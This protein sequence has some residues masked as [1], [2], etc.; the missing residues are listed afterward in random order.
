MHLPQINPSQ[1]AMPDQRRQSLAIALMS[2]R[3]PGAVQSPDQQVAALVAL[4]SP[5]AQSAQQRDPRT[6]LRG[7]SNS[8]C[9]PDGSKLAG[10]I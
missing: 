9:L 8:G 1:P 6:T 3:A 10:S 7:G 4:L 5:A 2:G